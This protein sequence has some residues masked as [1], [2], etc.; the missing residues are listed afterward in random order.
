MVT[1][2]LEILHIR[3]GGIHGY[4]ALADAAKARAVAEPDKAAALY[5]I[6]M[7]AE[8][9]VEANERM[10]LAS[11]GLVETSRAFSDH[12]AQIEAAYSADDAT[13]VLAALNA[14]SL[15]LARS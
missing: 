1:D 12:L 10:P 13:A 15:Y 9:F 3:G 4:A 6:A 7:A 11:P 8:S 14:L 2:L 5:I